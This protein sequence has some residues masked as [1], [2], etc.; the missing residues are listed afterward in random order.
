MKKLAGPLHL[1][2]VPDD[3]CESV[4]MDFIGP[5]PVDNG[6]DCILTITDRLNSD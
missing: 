2:P 1:L 4:T 6:F 5:L 3:Q